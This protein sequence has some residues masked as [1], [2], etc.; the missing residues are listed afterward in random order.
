MANYVGS[1][2]WV[3][4]GL[5]LWLLCTLP[6]KAQDDALPQHY[7]SFSFATIRIPLWVTDRNGLPYGDLERDDVQLLVDGSPVAIDNFMITHDSP[8]E[9]VYLLDL[10]GSMGMGGK[11]VGSI[12]T[13]DWLLTQH[14]QEDRWRIIVFSDGQILEV[15]NDETPEL[16]EQVKP[17]LRGYGKTALFDT[18][19][20]VHHYFPENSLN[21]RAVLV[22]T[23]G[24]DNHSELAEAQV[25]RV[26]KVIQVPLF[27]VGICDGFVPKAA[28]NQEKLGLQTLRN[29]ATITGG[30]LFLAESA[31]HLPIVG[32]ILREKL[33]PQYMMT[34]TVER[35][36][37][38]ERHD[39]AVRLVRK[40]PYQLRYRQGYLGSVPQYRGGYR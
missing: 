18:L 16:W 25:L 11:L 14:Q 29:I 39:I 35:A 7:Q 4:C 8:L 27:V 19:A 28:G 6:L 2:R 30:S 24:N 36:E 1:L 9:M 13:I 5:A 34:M 31:D 26:L 21:N 12:Q 37:N 40:S 10:S 33:R 20:A 32:R 15:A 3:W 17:K 23:D 38:D 22:F